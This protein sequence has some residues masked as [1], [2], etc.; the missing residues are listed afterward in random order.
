MQTIFELCVPRDDVLK[1]SIS[2]AD[3]AA[4][5]ALVVRDSKEA[6]EEYRIAS[7]F[8][9]N[10]Y[11][12]YYH[13]KNEFLYEIRESFDKPVRGFVE[14]P[15]FAQRFDN[16]EEVSRLVQTDKNETIAALF[17][18]GKHLIVALMMEGP[19][20]TGATLH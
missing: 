18:L 9:A 6:P 13:D 1:G 2:E 5:L 16:F 12:I 4:D 17:N 14:S 19:A 7:K 20:R 11:L 15:E 3:F 10:T 8:F